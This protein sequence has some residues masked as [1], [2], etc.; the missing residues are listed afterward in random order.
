MA[1]LDL[2]LEQAIAGVK[3]DPTN[4]LKRIGLFRMFSL[5][6]QWERAAT[7]LQTAVQMDAEQA[8]YAQ[9]YLNCIACER[10]RASVFDEG[11]QPLLL[12]EPSRWLALLVQ[13]LQASDVAMKAKLLGEAFDEAPATAGT[14]DGEAFE[15]IADVDNRFGPVLEAFLDGK[16]F[17]IPFDRLERVRFQPTQELVDTLWKPCEFVFS[18][19]GTKNG[20]VPLRYPGSELQEDE[21]LKLGRSTDYIPIADP[22]SA[23]IG[24]RLL[25]TDQDTVPLANVQEIKLAPSTAGPG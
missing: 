13:S 7:Q 2:T 15:W 4:P 25:S 17:W 5:Q 9:V 12:G 6:G 14:L 18:S 16:Y 23:A 10:F 19:G 8:M 24:A 11:R 22:Y 3:A 20:F 1:H 21:S